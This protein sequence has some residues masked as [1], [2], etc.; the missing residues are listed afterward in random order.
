MRRRGRTLAILT[1]AG[2]SAESGIPTFRDKN[3]LWENHRVEDVCSPRAFLHHPLVVQ[4]FYNQR[5]RALLSPEVKPNAAHMALARLERDY[6]KGE[7]VVITQNIDDLHER[8]GSKNVVHMHGELLKVRCTTT[9]NVFEWKDD[10]LHGQTKCACCGALGTLRPH[11]VWFEEVPLYMDVIS[12]VVEKADIFAAIG[13]SGNVYPAASFAS[14]A[15]ANG[16]ET[17]ELNLEPGEN[18]EDFQHN[19]YGPASVVVSKWVE[20]LLRGRSRDK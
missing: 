20:G 6:T 18:S 7:V 2:I 5:R 10:I 9:G 1:G 4:R 13:T 16:A 3:G 19:I 17:Y 12:D 15:A 14:L 8:A 11:I